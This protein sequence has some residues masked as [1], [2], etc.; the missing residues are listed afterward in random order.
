MASLKDLMIELLNSNHVNGAVAIGVGLYAIV[1]GKM[2]FGALNPT[3]QFYINGLPAILMGIVVV[4]IGA[5]LLLS[6]K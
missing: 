4:G 2:G 6:A 3:P 5:F 1:K